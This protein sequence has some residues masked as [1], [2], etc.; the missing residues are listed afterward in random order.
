MTLQ[1][2]SNEF[3][4]LINSYSIAGNYIV[5]TPVDL[6]E[7]EKSVLLTK[8]QDDLVRQIYNGS[9]GITLE[10][11]EEARR[12]L[13]AL[14]YTRILSSPEAGSL[15]GKVT[16][17]FDISADDE[18]P[19]VWYITY[20]SATLQH[21]SKVCFQSGKEV[22]VFPVRQDEFERIISNPFRGSNSNRVLRLDKTGNKIELVAPIDKK[23]GLPIRIAQYTIRYLKKPSPII[24]T[25]IEGLTIDGISDPTDC[26]LN[27][28]LHRPILERAVL[29]ALNKI[30]RTTAPQQQEEE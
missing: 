7:Y 3:D 26:E 16:Y 13:D 17:T 12:S 15:K 24:L 11:T 22:S 9:M 29:L 25:S 1:E 28:V 30:A 6:D 2:F 14:I 20:E 23:S 21:E 27:S 4:I 8:A 18:N 19:P 5:P 10:N